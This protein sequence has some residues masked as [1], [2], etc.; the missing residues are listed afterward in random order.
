[1]FLCLLSL[2]VCAWHAEQPFVAQVLL[3][4]VGHGALRGELPAH[5][6]QP[7]NLE[8]G[9]SHLDHARMPGVSKLIGYL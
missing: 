7:A 4:S 8:D 2:C 3:Q 9:A 6:K 1:M 5:V